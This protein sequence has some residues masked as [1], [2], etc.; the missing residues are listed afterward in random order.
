MLVYLA[1]AIGWYI[2][3]NKL[4]ECLEWRVSL[5]EKLNMLDVKCFNACT[6]LKENMSY[7]NLS[8]LKQNLFYLSESDLIIVN[9]DHI[10]E[11][12]GTIFELTYCYLKQKPV[13]GLGFNEDVHSSL[14]LSLCIDQCLK[15]E[16]EVLECVKNL[17]NVS[18]K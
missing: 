14:H 5:T 9:M 3:N 4:N 17:Y 2:R 11:S 8:N 10:L 7:S 15:D 16:G 1:G 18:I 13:I 6:N 12:P